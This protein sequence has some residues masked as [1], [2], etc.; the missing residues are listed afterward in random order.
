MA[1]VEAFDTLDLRLRIPD[2]WQQEALSLLREGHDVVVDAPTGAGKTYLVELL[3]DSNSKGQIVHTVPTRALANDKVREWQ[4]K[5]WRVGIVTGD[6]SI[7]PDAPLIVAT[8]ETQKQ[9]F[10]DGQGPDLFVVDEYQMLS[11]PTRGINY[12]HT[13]AMT[14]PDT[15]LL[16]LSGSVSNPQSVVD[17]LGRMGRDPK[18]VRAG[19]RPVP[20]EEARLEAISFNPP[21]SVRGFWPRL[22]AKALMADLGPIL[23][24]APLRSEAEKLAKHL[25]AALPIEEP[26]SL[27]REQ[28]PLAGNPLE[29]LLAKRVAFHHSGLSYQQRAGLVEPL[30]K[31]G[32][33]RVVVATTGLAAGVNFSMRSVAVTNAQYRIDYGH[34]MLRPDELLQM[35][36][37]AG[38]RGLDEVGYALAISDRPRLREARPL[39]VKRPAILDWPSLIGQMAKAVERQEDP[40]ETAAKACGRLFSERPIAIGVEHSIQ[41][42]EAPCGLRDDA[43]RARFARPDKIEMR[44]TRGDWEPLR[45]EKMVP[46]QDAR[47][48][49]NGHWRPLLSLADRVKELGPGGLI[50]F[51][52]EGE[53]RFGLRVTIAFRD[54]RAPDRFSLARWFREGMARIRGAAVESIPKKWE[55][56]ALAALGR[57]ELSRVVAMGECVAAG[58][59]G[60]RW[61]LRMDLRDHGIPARLDGAGLGVVE[62]ETRESTPGVCKGCSEYDWCREAPTRRTPVLAWQQLNLIDTSGRPTPRGHVFSFFN[63]GEGLAIAAALE[64]KSYSVDAIAVDIA[65]LRAGFRF[66]EHS[67]FSHRLA[68][69]CRLA[70]GDRSYEGYLKHG[71]PP[72]YGEGAAEVIAAILDRPSE[73]R[74]MYDESLKPGDV[75]RVRLEWQSLLRQIAYAPEL[76]WERWMELK[77]SVRLYLDNDAS[78]M[79][80]ETLPPLEPKQRQR[81]NH[82][83]RFPRGFQ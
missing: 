44:N 65:N 58:E 70:Y 29:K 32:Q 71:L 74:K 68:R 47:L 4:E 31:A 54:S 14:P 38:R 80:L 25:A 5:G 23:L 35:F 15:R 3:F 22:I 43:S 69:S 7:D 1:R 8:L 39:P 42:P 26:L 19:K 63:G 53:K 82:R 46:A 66:D 61:T 6:L 2:L 77:Q 49:S 10:L 36:G 18:L 27:S 57:E 17:W 51:S 52:G 16:L 79:G 50:A 33:L 12:E 41:F 78:I 11:D 37:R 28:K 60:K 24:F 48:Y 9:R 56:G 55:S 64:E 45:E 20:L 75:Q 81:A 62:P 30:A 34:E 59:D 67:Q 73:A 76:D 72:Q 40:F 21:K 13:I 83:L